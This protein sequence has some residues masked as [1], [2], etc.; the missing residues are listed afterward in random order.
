MSTR[1]LVVLGTA[2]QVPTRYRNHNGY[3]MLWDDRGLL[4]DPGEGVQRQMI[5]AGVASGR[6]TRILITHFHGDHCLGLPGVL[7]R[8][9][10]DGVPHPVTVHYPDSGQR[11]FDRLRHASIYRDNATIISE[12]VSTAGVVHQDRAF[13]IEARQLSH[14]APTWGWQVRE[15]DGHAFVPQRLADHGL[16]GPAVGVLRR[17]GIVVADGREVRLEDV[18]VARPGQSMAFIMDTRLCDAAF[19]L[20]VGVDMLVCEATYAQS[21]AREAHDHGHLT[22]AQ[23]GRIAAEG[24]VNTLVLTHFSQRYRNTDQHVR[25]ARAVFDGR[26]IAAEDLL[27]VPMPRRGARPR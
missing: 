10:L 7:Q 26:V 21:E 8:I 4:F 22:A 25:E 2:S 15:P 16:T 14:S 6:I 24:G 5:L 11:F 27:R 18:S 9:S 13:T 23:A 3:L 20:A 1:E 17:E 19:E 12:P